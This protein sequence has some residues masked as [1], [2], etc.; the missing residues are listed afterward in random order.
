MV[1]AGKSLPTQE[2]LILS[3]FLPASGYHTPRR[4][5]PG[6]QISHRS[7]VLSRET[8]FYI[9]FYFLFFVRKGRNSSFDVGPYWELMSPNHN[10]KEEYQFWYQINVFRDAPSWAESF[11]QFRAVLGKMQ[12][13]LCVP[14]KNLLPRELASAWWRRRP[15]FPDVT[16]LHEPK[17]LCTSEWLL[18][19]RE[20]ILPACMHPT[21]GA[22]S[23][24]VLIWKPTSAIF[25]GL[26]STP[27]VQSSSPKPPK[28]SAWTRKW[29]SSRAN[30]K[31]EL[32]AWLLTR[33]PHASNL[34]AINSLQHN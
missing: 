8:F 4:P 26:G 23:F 13:S 1:S 30:S 20:L 12:D 32:A 3:P 14:G 33:S 28:C 29:P 22:V 7:Y 11:Q 2:F 25:W 21:F 18:P 31:L 27:S 17:P 16:G 5:V 34:A 19:R 9:Y 10:V 15:S 6:E 24:M